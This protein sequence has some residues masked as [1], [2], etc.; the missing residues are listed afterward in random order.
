VGAEAGRPVEDLEHSAE[1]AAF[2]EVREVR[3]VRVAATP[4][5]PATPAWWW[6]SGVMTRA[7]AATSP[8]R[9]GLPAA[10]A[11][12]PNVQPTLASYGGVDSSPRMWVCSALV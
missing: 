4:P 5:T 1:T 8:G 6:W 12:P 2:L 3:E 7:P 10:A 11:R 9:A